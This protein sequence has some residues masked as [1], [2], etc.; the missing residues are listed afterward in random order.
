ML[1]DIQNFQQSLGVVSYR[2]AGCELF[3]DNKR[4]AILRRLEAEHRIRVGGPRNSRW[5]VTDEADKKGHILRLASKYGP[6]HLNW[7]HAI[8]GIPE[9]AVLDICFDLL[10][11]GK[12][13][14]TDLAI[15]IPDSFG[16]D[17]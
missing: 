9:Q 2:A 10:R 15:D 3:P 12:I 11:E 17:E 7:M 13:I 5:C 14:L 6:V 8:V 1:Q 4:L 16:E